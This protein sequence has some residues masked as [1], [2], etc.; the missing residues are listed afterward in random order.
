MLVTRAFYYSVAPGRS[1]CLECWGRAAAEDP[2]RINRGTGPVAG[3]LGAMIGL[4]AL[5]YL[6]GFAPPVA[7]GK[8]WM[9]D[10]A[11]GRVE[12]GHEWS[13]RP[14]CRFCGRLAASPGASETAAEA[15]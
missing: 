3:L 6:T 9:L 15:A 12:I 13:A 2:H 7:A 8:V 11:T 1:A 5:R 4:E 10:L 14:D